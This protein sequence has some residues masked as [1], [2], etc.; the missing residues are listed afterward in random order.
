MK[1]W[2]KQHLDQCDFLMEPNDDIGDMN[3]EVL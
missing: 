1:N 2:S 3:H